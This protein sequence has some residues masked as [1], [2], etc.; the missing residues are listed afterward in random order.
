[1]NSKPQDPK[2]ISDTRSLI[3]DATEQ[4]M[5]GEGYAG[6]SS[7]KVAAKAG[8]KSNPLHYYFQSMD[9]LFIA[10]FRRLEE[11]YDARF[12]QAAASNRPL[13]DLW[14][15]AR[16]SVGGKLILEFTA[17]ASHRPALRDVIGRS[18]RRDRRIMT[19]A[20]STIFKRYGIDSALFP[21]NLV[22]IVSA[23]LTRALS[24]ER[25]LEAEE[26]HAEA[27]DYV[28]HL[29]RQIEPGGKSG[30]VVAHPLPEGTS[31]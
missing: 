17:L 9:E 2:A 14:A 13:H 19:A 25:V 24:T 1:M 27:L 3:M 12:V 29:L 6:V 22:A 8:L 11:G 4:I 20:L 21:P 16:D 7:R 10:T 5:I 18:A 15:L 23:G 26:G 31:M 28:D 30:A